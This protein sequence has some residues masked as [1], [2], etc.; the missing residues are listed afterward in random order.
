MNNHE[1]KTNV[2]NIVKNTDAIILFIH[3]KYLCLRYSYK[4]LYII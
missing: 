3:E 1:N 2:A 4:S